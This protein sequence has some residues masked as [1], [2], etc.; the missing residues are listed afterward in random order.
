[1]KKIIIAVLALAMA[2]C[3]Q[4]PSA[5]AAAIGLYVDGSSGGGL[6]DYW[7][8]EVSVSTKGAGLVMETN[9]MLERL[10]NFRLSLGAE[11]YT[12]KYDEPFDKYGNPTGNDAEL[13]GYALTTDFGFRVKNGPTLY[14]WLGPE[15][16][17]SKYNGKDPSGM[18][19]TAFAWSL[20]LALGANM[21]LTMDTILSLKACYLYTTIDDD[22]SIFSTSFLQGEPR[23]AYISVGILFQ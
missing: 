16:R 21:E 7:D 3:I 8:T 19:I 9:P 18:D 2:F 6:E 13:E 20:G 5:H 23:L 1:M 22:S 4:T 17:L 10:F 15:L 11:E 14:M 12:W